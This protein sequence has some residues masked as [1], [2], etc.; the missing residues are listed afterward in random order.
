MDTENKRKLALELLKLTQPVTQPDYGDVP[1]SVRTQLSLAQEKHASVFLDLYVKLYSEEQL[2]AQFDFYSSE[3]GK[4]ILK[5][6]S[7]V[8][9]EFVRILPE[10]NQEQNHPEPD[11]E[12]LNE[13]LKN[14]KTRRV[15]QVEKKPPDESD[16]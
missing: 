12:E 13:L 2:Q 14:V 6:Q 5:T 8:N 16:T 4:S 15:I 9:R 3:M 10:L 11:P 1:E 7:E